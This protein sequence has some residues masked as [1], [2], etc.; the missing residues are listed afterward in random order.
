[1]FGDVKMKKIVVF[2]V[3]ISV[4][5]IGACTR[6]TDQPEN[7]QP[8]DNQPNV[9]G[10]KCQ[11]LG[12]KWLEE[13]SECEGI[14]EQVCEELGGN[15]NQCASACRNDPNA[16]MCTMQCVQVCSFN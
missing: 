4:F 16:E 11:E 6:N 5:L 13:F 15:F 3:I 2:M 1:M 14:S 8:N 10:E 12:G 7:I 9:V